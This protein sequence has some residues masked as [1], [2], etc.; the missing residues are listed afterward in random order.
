MEIDKI[1]NGAGSRELSER[2]N[3]LRVFIGEAKEAFEDALEIIDENHPLR[4]Q[5]MKYIQ[6]TESLQRRL[7][8]EM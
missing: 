3:M 1:G 4:A 8:I 5:I 7:I 2:P 6:D